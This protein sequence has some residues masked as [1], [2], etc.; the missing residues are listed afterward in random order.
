MPAMM[1]LMMTLKIKHTDWIAFSDHLFSTD[2]KFSVNVEVLTTWYAYVHLRTSVSGSKKCY[3]DGKI[4]V[5]TKWMIRCLEK[6]PEAFK[7]V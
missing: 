6:G 7:I 1:T 5:C 4:R 3:F 2:V